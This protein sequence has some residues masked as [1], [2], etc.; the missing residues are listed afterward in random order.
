M[1]AE[2]KTRRTYELAAEFGDVV[3]SE[4][5][6]FDD[7]AARAL[8]VVTHRPHGLVA[9]RVALPQSDVGDLLV[10]VSRYKPR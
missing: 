4:L 7:D 10:P 8:E 6:V 3:V 5:D 2:I 9:L 1:V